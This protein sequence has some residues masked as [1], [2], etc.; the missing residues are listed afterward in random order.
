MCG[1]QHINCSFAGLA[2]H[3]WPQVP[4]VPCEQ[5]SSLSMHIP[6]QKLAQEDKP[7]FESRLK[8]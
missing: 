2:P 7:T 6:H 3:T 5:G 8:A 1:E 4:S